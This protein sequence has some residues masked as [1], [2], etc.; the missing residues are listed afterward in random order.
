M[1]NYFM[2]HWELNE[3]EKLTFF[4]FKNRTEE[5]TGKAFR[6]YL[7]NFPIFINLE[8]KI[9]YDGNVLNFS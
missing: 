9:N 5:F 1:I 7:Q 6:K 8:R 3:E 2:H 4:S